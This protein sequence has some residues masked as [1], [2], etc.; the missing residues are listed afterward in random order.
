VIAIILGSSLFVDITSKSGLFSWI[1][2]KVTKAS[3]GDPLLLLIFYGIMTVIFSAVL[4]N[5]TAMIIVGS[6]TVVS[7][8]KL[9]R[10]EQLLGFL[11]IE[12]L[13][14]NIGGLLTLISSVPNIIIGT[15]AEISF[16]TFFIKSAPFVLVAT[17]ITL[18]LGS[19][20]FKIKRLKTEEEKAEA[21]RLV[22]GFDENDG[23]ESWGFFKFAA[24]MLVL[25]ILTIATTSVLPGISSLGMGFVAM[26]FAMVMLCFSP[27]CSS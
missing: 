10:R 23:V 4:N 24:A 7:L 9:G 22:A 13:L 25:F 12:G 1:A 14:T 6:L 18:F 2:I 17:F 27:L 20:L 15:V 8:D 26:A 5:V 16:V 21:R 19:F 11:L 3:R